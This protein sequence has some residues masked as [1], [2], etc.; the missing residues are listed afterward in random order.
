MTWMRLDLLGP[1]AVRDHTGRSQIVPASLQP[2]LGFLTLEG[3]ESCHRERVIDRLWPDLSPEQ[4]RR[5]LN[6]AVWRARALFG[7]QRDAIISTRGGYLALDPSVVTVDIMPVVAA[8]T[9]ECRA[10][11]AAGDHDALERLR[12][13]VT[14][15]AG[16]LLAGNYED[17]VIEARHELE[18]SI[19]RG[20]ETLLDA[21]ATAEETIEWSCKLVALDPLREDAHRRLIRLYA[22]AGRRAD[23]LRQ[24]DCCVRYLRDELGAEPLIETTLAAAAV[25]EGLLDG[26]DSEH[27][28]RRLVEVLR[29]AL[30]ACQAAVDD[31]DASL[32]T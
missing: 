5:R 31:L 19:T 30:R 10:A 20:I 27:D 23:A 25:R 15:D 32:P 6:T 11:A 26:V 1:P 24:Y 9:S 13:A 4:G 7:G 17:W 12:Q 22:E 21:S 14:I 18:L 3:V 28:A 8:L 29:A 2:L 16:R